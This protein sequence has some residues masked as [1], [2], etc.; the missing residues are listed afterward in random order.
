MKHPVQ[1]GSPKS[2]SLLSGPWSTSAPSLCI[3]P[4]LWLR[5]ALS[6]LTSSEREGDPRVP[7]PLLGASP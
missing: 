4:G 1:D 7:K 2:A 5:M 6:S 3:Q